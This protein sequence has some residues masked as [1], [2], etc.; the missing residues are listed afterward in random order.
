M[1]SIYIDMDDVLS[2][3]N[4]A[5]LDIL[6]RDF[7]KKVAYSQ[8]KSFDLKESFGLTEDEY[9]HFF[10]CIHHPDE[11]IHHAPVRGSQE[12]LRHWHQNGYKIRIL[13]GRPLA[14]K[15]VS[16]QWLDMHGFYH[17]SFFIVNKY[18]RETS[19]GE[20]TLSL[21]A[22]STC[23]FDLAVE[24][25]GQMARFLSE[26]MGVKVALLDRPWNRSMSFNHNVVR[27]K[28]WTDIKKKFGRL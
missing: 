21:E 19:N 20:Q 18:G 17:D 14:A 24:D 28:H 15:E 25:S 13:T 7:N 23:H 3:S 10:N 12:V 8:I 6:E 22:L 11:M 5:F 2:E 16:L 9:S 26:K 27:C 4:Q 1:R